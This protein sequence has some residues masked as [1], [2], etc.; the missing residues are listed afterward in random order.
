RGLSVEAALRFPDMHALLRALRRD[1]ARKVRRG[2]VLATGI[3]G[4]GVGAVLAFAAASGDRELCEGTT[5]RLAGVWDDDVRGRVQQA[6]ERSSVAYAPTAFAGVEQALGEYTEAWARQHHEA[7][8]ATHVHHDQSQEMLDLRMQCLR[9]RLGEVGALVAE[10]ESADAA[11]IEHA[12]EAAESLGRLESCSDTHALAA[13]VRPPEDAR[14]R[15]LVDRLRTSLADAKAKESAGRY[16]A[17]LGLAE[18]VALRAAG[19]GYPPVLAEA[20]LRLGSVLERKGEFASAERELLEAIWHAEASHH[21]SVAADAWVRL[22]WVTGVERGDTKT[23]E[24]WINFADAAVQ[25]LGTNEL[26]RATL[27]HNQGG[28]RYTQRRLDEAFERYREALEIQQRLLGPDDPQVAMTYNHMGNVKIEQ[29]DL[30]TAREYVLRSYEVRRRVLGERHPKVAASI[31]NLAVIASKQ[32]DHE[33]ALVQVERALAIVGDSGGAEEI[34]GLVV[35]SES[36]LELHASERAVR[37]LERLLEL[38]ELAVPTQPG[39]VASALEQLA[40]AR[41]QQARLDEAV[42]LLDRAIRVARPSDPRRSAEL[43]MRL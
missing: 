8:E 9:A 43:A 32:A 28:L 41:E 17:A 40:R 23:G 26:L 15:E 19:L 3:V 42:A 4:V 6:F 2:L 36:A 18:E 16:D 11:V 38:R 1:Q 35:G 13:R 5:E 24:L 25:R 21:E 30:A 14:T 20:R 31:N 10:L 27:V 37:Y 34:V 7:C 22:V 12:V 39:Q 29:G 33:E